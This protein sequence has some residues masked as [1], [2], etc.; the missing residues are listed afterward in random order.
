MADKCQSLNVYSSPLRP[1]FS[2][3]ALVTVREVS[4]ETH[5]QGASIPLLGL[6]LGGEWLT[7]SLK[8]TYRS[9]ARLSPLRSDSSSMRTPAPF[10]GRSSRL[11]R[12]PRGD[13]IKSSRTGRAK[14]IRLPDQSTR[15]DEENSR[16]LQAHRIVQATCKTASCEPF[17]LVL[18]KPLWSST[19]TDQPF[20]DE[21]K[22]CEAVA[23]RAP[24]YVESCES[25]FTSN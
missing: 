10:T 24:T 25:Q 5:I 4:L 14:S 23:N 6:K 22:S 17:L 1:S 21:L 12:Y 2:S 15:L 3:S 7:F 9:R 18:V 16:T 20:V 8:Q 19:T 13:N 11:P